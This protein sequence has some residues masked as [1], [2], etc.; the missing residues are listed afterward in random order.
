[1]SNPKQPEPGVQ[2][3]ASASQARIGAG[4]VLLLGLGGVFLWLAGDVL[5]V[6]FAGLLLAVGIDGL[7]NGLSGRTRL[8][9]GVSFFVVVALLLGLIAAAG[10]LIVPQVM[11][12]VGDLVELFVKAFESARTTIQRWG[13]PEE[14]LSVEAIGQGG[15]MDTAGAVAGRLAGITVATLGAVGTVIVALT[16]ALFAAW[17]PGLH[18]RGVLA[19]LPP[20]E[21]GRWGEALAR[22]GHALRWWFLGQLVSMA[23]LAVTV[24]LGLWVIGVELWL[25]LGV[26]TGLLTFI[27]ILGPLIAAVPILVVAFAEGAQTGLIVLAFYLVVQ[28]VEGNVIVP[29]IQQQAVDLPPVLLISAQLVLGALFGLPGFILAAPLTVVAMVMVRRLHVEEMERHDPA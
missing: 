12:Q 8:R 1:M 21:R 29:M 14:V 18:R 27:P 24:S 9:R 17:D 3:R 11:G 2:P 5:L 20:S 6:V 7:A 25:S 13:W 22:T 19:V 28:N 15:I 26:L 16:I 10:A 4:R 23:L